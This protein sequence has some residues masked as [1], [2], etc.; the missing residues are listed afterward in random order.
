MAAGDRGLYERIEAVFHVHYG[1]QQKA[2]QP[3]PGA[4]ETIARLRDAAA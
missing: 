2:I 3:F 1:E 4:V